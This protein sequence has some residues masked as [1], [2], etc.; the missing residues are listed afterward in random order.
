MN[1]LYTLTH[2]SR[3]GL[4]QFY[5]GEDS[6]QMVEQLVI[7]QAD[8]IRKKHPKMGCRTMHLLMENITIGRD[9]CEAI[10][11]GHGFRV[12]RRIN[13]IKTT[14]SQRNLHFPDLIRG[15]M[16]TGI[17][18]VWQTDI[19]YYLLG[20]MVLYIVFIIDV[21]SR[22]IIGYTANNHMKAKAN[23]TCLTNAFK[24]R[25]DHCL[26]GLIHHSD[27]G[28]QYGERTYLTTL[29][30]KGIQIS[31]CKQAWQNAYTERINGILKNDYLYTR[32][33][34]TLTQLRRV[35]TIDVAAYNEEKPHGS[36]FKKMSPVKFENY[37]QQTPES[38]HP[39]LKIYDYEEL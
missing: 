27:R 14:H 1:A 11:L 30:D 17:N 28:S 33:I 20:N 8:S 36:L 29:Q 9:L 4:H 23:L 10:L 2:T 3:Q 12:K 32:R 35:L 34:T 21:Y 5:N 31:M 24:T 38:T 25:K 19:T 26:K 7:R 18:Q 13:H 39:K 16:V 22:R 37:L 15:R 6:H